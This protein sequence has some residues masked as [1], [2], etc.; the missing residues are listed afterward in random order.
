VQRAYWDFVFT[1]RNL[2]IQ[3]D[4][5]RDARMQLEHNRRLVAEGQLAPVDIVA[6]EAQV[7]G[8]EQNIYVALDEVGRAENA[9]KNLIAENRES[10][11]WSVALVPTDTVDVQ[12]PVVTL[13]DAMQS[14][15]TTRPELQQ[16]DVAGEI[17]ALDER[18][19]REATKPQV[20]L[21][22][23]YG[24]VGL[25]GAFDPTNVNPFS[26]AN[27][28]LRARINQL[29]ALNGLDPLPAS[30]ASVCNSIFH[31]ATARLRHSW[32]ARLSSATASACSANS[33]NS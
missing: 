33:L 14:A 10:E 17:N 26:G 21:V 4:A 19:A 23:S 6:A 5:A 32:G 8:F 28:Q 11:V 12:P 30:S 18:L 22:G 27:D 9:L 3:R 15:L 25:A 16:S 7:A 1:L 24:A 20:D 31:C 29:S 2:Q 13:E